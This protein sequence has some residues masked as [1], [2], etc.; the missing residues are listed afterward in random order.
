MNITFQSFLQYKLTG[1]H[2]SQMLLL[3]NGL[4]ILPQ[5][6]EPFPAIQKDKLSA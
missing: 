3:E 4:L 2:V 5:E 1:C 6:R